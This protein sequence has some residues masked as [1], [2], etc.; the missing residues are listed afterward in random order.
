[1]RRMTPRLATA[2]LL[3]ALAL[4]VASAPRADAAASVQSYAYTTTGDIDGMSGRPPIEFIGQSG[5]NVLTAP[6]SFNLGSFQANLLPASATLTY[7]NTPFTIDL[8][9]VDN[10]LPGVL[11]FPAYA[12]DTDYKISGVLNGSITGD[13]HSTMYARMTS[14]V[15][16]ADRGLF[17]EPPFPV[18]DIK[19]LAPQGINAPDGKTVGITSLGAQ[20]IIP[21]FPLPAPAPEP[22]SVAAFAVA[23]AGWA[24]RKKA[25]ARG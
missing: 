18:S 4:I 20:V 1:M 16:T 17:G 15:D 3:A 23:L 14:I 2:A 6:G 19:V 13:G 7:D 21:G 25:R 22:T 24:L 11:Y 9:V 5:P 12:Y 10:R 8:H